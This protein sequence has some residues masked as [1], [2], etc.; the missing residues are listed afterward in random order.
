MRNAYRV[1]AVAIAIVESLW[2]ARTAALSWP[3]T[4]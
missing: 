3:I 2:L 1:A 4:F